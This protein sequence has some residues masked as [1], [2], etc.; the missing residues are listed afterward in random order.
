MFKFYL[1]FMPVFLSYLQEQVEQ[2]FC[3]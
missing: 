1:L 2:N 3:L